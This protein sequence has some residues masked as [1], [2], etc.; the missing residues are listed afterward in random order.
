[1][2]DFA[3]ELSFDASSESAVRGCWE[4]L[5]AAGL[6]SQ[7]DNARGM[8]NQ[9]HVSLVVA[10]EIP[11][12]V[13]EF[14]R[15]ELAGQLPTTLDVRGLVLLGDSAKVTVAL[16]AEP[17]VRIA[18]VV[19]K[20]RESTPAVRHPVWTPHVTLGRRI[21][22]ERIGEALTVLEPHRPRTL[23]ADRLRW[24][25]PVAGTIEQLI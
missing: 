16:L 19:A 1:M 9:P 22:R 23:V 5:A 11:S 15:S 3:L 6:P 10:R 25:D 13:A 4:A 20:L 7:A 21:P 14:A 24:W 2:A 18:R 12:A 8:V 17:D